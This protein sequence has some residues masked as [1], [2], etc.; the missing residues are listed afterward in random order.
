MKLNW[1]IKEQAIKN[2]L[3]VHAMCKIFFPRANQ[4]FST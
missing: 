2:L 4:K 1:K 3:D